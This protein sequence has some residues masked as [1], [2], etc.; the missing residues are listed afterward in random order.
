MNTFQ[1]T[2]IV[3]FQNFIHSSNIERLIKNFIKQH[4]NEEEQPLNID[5][6]KGIITY[7][8][9][10]DDKVLEIKFETQLKELLWK[11]TNDIKVEIDLSNAMLSQKE[12]KKYW[13]TILMSFDFMLESNQGVFST[14]PICIKPSEEIKDYLKIKYQF[15]FE[16]QYD[17]PSYFTLKRNYSR[18]DLKKIYNFMDDFSFIDADK[19]SFD[20][21]FSIFNYKDVKLVLQFDTSTEVMVCLLS[22]ISYL[23]TDFTRKKIH[24]SARFITKSGKV[25]SVSNYENT[26]KRIESKSN[27]DLNN[28]RKF[29]SENFPK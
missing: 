25:L 27:S 16:N 20:D 9:D 17:S 7:Y 5:S 21:F 3:N 23:Y 24:E 19:Y 14:F 6:S 10:I 15:P 8:N 28:I 29:F 18:A 4:V 11:V 2:A 22:E 12:K 1:P 26:I 13:D